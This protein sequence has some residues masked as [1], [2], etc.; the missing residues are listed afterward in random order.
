M[1][2][3][4]KV[5]VA[6]NAHYGVST[7]NPGWALE[8][9]CGDWGLI[10]KERDWEY[11]MKIPDCPPKNIT[12]KKVEMAMLRPEIPVPEVRAAQSTLPKVGVGVM[13]KVPNQ[14]IDKW[15]FGLV[16]RQ[17]KKSIKVFHSGKFVNRN[18]DQF[19]EVISES[20]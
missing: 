10:K 1:Q 5:E 3:G 11:P 15:E 2:V 7:W 18:F 17:N 19:I 20:R 16:V 14:V 4:D 12:R 8:F 13:F 9:I 6:F